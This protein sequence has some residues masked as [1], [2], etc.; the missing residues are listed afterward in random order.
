[1]LFARAALPDYL[2]WLMFARPPAI[3]ILVHP[4]TRSQV[5]D[6]TARALWLG[7]PLTL[8]RQMLEAEDARLL[9][10]A[11]ASKNPYPPS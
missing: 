9:A 7:T 11:A 3:D 8:D 5:L 6:H 4:L 2:P 10:S 1:M